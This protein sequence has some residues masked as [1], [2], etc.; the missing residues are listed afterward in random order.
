[1]KEKM[2]FGPLSS[3]AALLGIAGLSSAGQPPD[4][5]TSDSTS[6]TAMGTQALQGLTTGSN[7]IEIGNQGLAADKK[8]IRIGA[9]GTQTAAYVA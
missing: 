4:I 9:S 6:N 8:T 2:Q 1:M 3:A 5:V 7:N